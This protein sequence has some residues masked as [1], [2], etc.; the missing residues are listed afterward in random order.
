MI[1]HIV[2]SARQWKIFKIKSNSSRDWWWWHKS[3]TSSHKWIFGFFFSSRNFYDYFW[4]VLGKFIF[5]VTNLFKLFALLNEYQI[6][7][8]LFWLLLLIFELEQLL[9]CVMHGKWWNLSRSKNLRMI[10][11]LQIFF[12][13]IILKYFKRLQV[14]S[15]KTL[16]FCTFILILDSKDVDLKS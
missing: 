5:S 14:S 6:S 16:W 8:T 13:K 11:S 10:E 3:I 15:L 2:S 9:K 4:N 12:S 1:S 7:N